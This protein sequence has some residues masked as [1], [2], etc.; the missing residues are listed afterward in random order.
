ML[1][2]TIDLLLSAAG[3]VMV[4]PVLGFFA[5]AVWS[6]DFCWPFYVSDRI[7]RDGKTFRMVKLRSM[8]SNAD[9]S[10]V[11]STSATD[12]RITAIGRLIRKLKLDELTQLWNVVLGDMSLVG[13]RP[14]VFK[15]GVELYTE[16]E[17]RLLSVRPGITDFSSIVFADEGAILKDA[18]NPDLAY[19]QLIR[20]W[21]S[22]LSLLY[23]D[24]Q[25]AW[26][27]VK[28]VLITALTIVSR[29]HA[30]K[31]VVRELEHLHAPMQLIE[32]ASRTGAL[33]PFPPP[34]E[35]EVVALREQIQ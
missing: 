20:P 7:G 32:V 31:Q 15:W 21:K 11:T 25:S 4:S 17:M 5:V 35:T 23:I 12:N 1:K 14:N 24:H 6:Q 22:R 13:P 2:R 9:R 26:L 27:D 18:N 3:L 16:E 10:G 28:L 30:L 8:V 34:G 33:K 29:P 19:N